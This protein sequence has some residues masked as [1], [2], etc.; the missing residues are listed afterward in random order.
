MKPSQ[1][2]K[3]FIAGR[4]AV[5]PWQWLKE[6]LEELAEICE[7]GDQGAA[8]VT[9]MELAWGKN[10]PPFDLPQDDA[11]RSGKDNIE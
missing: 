11:N 8:R 2:S 5:P 7:S 9:L 3:I 4:I 1:H 6:Q 10:S